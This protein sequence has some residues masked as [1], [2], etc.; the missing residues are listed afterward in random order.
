[1]WEAARVLPHNSILLF[2][3]QSIEVTLANNKYRLRRATELGP[4]ECDITEIAASPE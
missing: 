2:A 1:M 4:T 3:L